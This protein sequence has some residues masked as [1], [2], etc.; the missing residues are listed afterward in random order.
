[1]LPVHWRWHSTEIRRLEKAQQDSQ[2]M[3][4]ASG[5]RRVGAAQGQQ[6]AGS[7]IARQSAAGRVAAG[8]GAGGRLTLT[9]AA[10]HQGGQHL[11][12]SSSPSLHSCREHT[13]SC[14]SWAFPSVARAAGHER[15]AAQD[16]LTS[17]AYASVCMDAT[18]SFTA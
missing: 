1:M 5:R 14:A 7:F 3:T 4:V 18:S 6:R 9:D 13:A 11:D 10:L 15:H 2:G 8:V 17:S 16:P 12:S